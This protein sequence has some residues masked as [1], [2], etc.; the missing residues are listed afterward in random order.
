MAALQTIQAATFHSTGGGMITENKPTIPVVAHVIT[1]EDIGALQGSKLIPMN[2]N[3]TIKLLTDPHS[4]MLYDRHVNALQRVLRHYTKGFPMK[5]LVQVFKILNVCSDRVNEQPRYEQFI[6]DILKICSLPF[7]KEKSSDELVF[8]QIVLESVSQLG[9]LMRVPSIAVRKQIC[10]T[11]L[12]FFTEIPDKQEVQYH[13]GTNLKYNQKV[14]EDSDIAETLVK[15]LALLESELPV[16][17]AV[18]N[19]LQKFS[20]HSA[21]ICDSMLRADAAHR[22]CSR[23]MDPDPSGQL[24]FRSSEILWNLLEN[25]DKAVLA[26]QLN[27]LICISQLRDA[28]IYQ[29]TQGYSHYDRQLRNDLLVLASLIAQKCPNTPF[30][31]T[32]FAKQ[33]V[34]FSTFQ[35]VKSHNAL[36][37][38]LKLMQNHED[39]ELKKLLFN[40]MVTMGNDSTALPILSEGHLM[41]ALFSFVRAN[42]SQSGPREWTPAQFEELQLQAMSSLC[43]LCPKMLD[44]YMTV[45]GSTR[46][47]LLLEWCVGPEDF[48]G[49]GNSLHGVGGRGNKRAQMRFCLRV[50]RSVVSTGDELALQDLADQGAINQIITIL[51]NAVTSNTEDDAIDVEMQADMMMILSCLCDGDMHRKEL[52][53]EAGVNV[54]VHYLRTDPK[55]LSS[56]LGHHRL[57][58]T[59]VDCVWCSIVGCYTTEDYLLE[60]EGIFLLIDLLEACPKNMHNLILG[61]LLDLCENPKTVH[62]VLTWR[63]KDNSS[64]AHLFC[65]TWRSEE[66]DLGVKRDNN[67]AIADVRRPLMGSLQDS[68]GFIPLPAGCMSQAIVDVSENMR[69]KIYSIFCKIGFT[70]LPGLTVDDHITLTVI[71][72]YL[73][74]KM[75]EVWTEVIT[76]LD[77]ERVRPTT[78]DLEA[79]EAISRAIENR[80]EIVAG[81]QQELLEAQQSQDTLNEQEFYAEIRENYRQKEKQLN[82]FSDFVARTSNYQL[83]KAAKERQEYSIEASRIPNEYKKSNFFHEIN[84][85]NIKTTTFASKHVVVD[86]TPIDLTGGPLSNYD[87]DTGTNKTR[88][89]PTQKA[90]TM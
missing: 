28:F 2:L 44:D 76:E 62:H 47:L 83:L 82:D 8:E 59:A 81:T 84:L 16:K 90:L 10:E 11:L 41:L 69:A 23:L 18:L 58:L 42:E 46:I 4:S 20:K 9:Y 60:K 52:F 6:I 14:V 89:L 5:D 74:F 19:V 71:E 78:P 39:F 80:A 31:E 56:G 32:G 35:E 34:L 70:D 49:H 67:G 54:C 65:E 37:K 26:Q 33:L 1:D 87:P 21:K 68:K 29:L 30:V 22:V 75:G 48:G 61:C 17:L 36:V 85:P 3:R 66:R 15:S 38:H 88:K 25:G 13:K 40:I 55:L 27:N 43:S 64:A 12:C 53:G 7:L 73:D 57:L 63:G 86:S 79:V 51:T 45:Q 24:L 72:K 50:L 77:Q